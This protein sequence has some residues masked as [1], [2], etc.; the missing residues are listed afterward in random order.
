MAWP[1]SI[2]RIQLNEVK[3]RPMDH[4]PRFSLVPNTRHGP[5]ISPFPRFSKGRILI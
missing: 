4:I 3:N 5:K 1:M 2:D